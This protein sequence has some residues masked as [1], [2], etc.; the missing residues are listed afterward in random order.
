LSIN[1]LTV[2]GSLEFGA[3]PTTF[4]VNG[5]LT[6][7]AGAEFLVFNGTTGKAIVVTGNIVND[8]NIDLSIGATTTGSLTLNGTTVQSITGSG[9]FANNKIRNLIFSNT[10]TA[11]PNI[12]WGFD[13]ISVEYNLTISNAKIDL[14]GNKINYGV[15]ATSTG[16]TFAFTNG[17]F[18]N[19][20]FSRWWTSAAT[21]YTTSGPTTIP[22]G[23]AGR[24]PFYSPTGEQRIFYLG[25]TT[26]TVEVNMQ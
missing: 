26:P 20:T 25:R 5:N 15:S 11:I 9:T 14:G 10:S 18:L 21:G 16:N 4:N 22:T 19:G 2:Q 12:N 13:D 17:G 8:G 7:E 3:T 23:A 24:Y 6:L 1:N